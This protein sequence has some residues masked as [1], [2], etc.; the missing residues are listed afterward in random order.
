MNKQDQNN[1][2]YPRLLT[3]QESES[4]LQDM[5]ESSAWARPELKRWRAA[6]SDDLTKEENR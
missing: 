2:H 6:K 1:G 5:K 3:P 4:L